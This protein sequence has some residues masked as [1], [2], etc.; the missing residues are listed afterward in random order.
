[1][2]TILKE[3]RV[4]A[5]GYPTSGGSVAK[6]SKKFNAQVWSDGR[7]LLLDSG[8][9]ESTI[10]LTCD[11][12]AVLDP[13]KKRFN[14][15]LEAEVS[16]AMEPDEDAVGWAEAIAKALPLRYFGGD[17][18]NW[19]Q[20]ASEVPEF[21]TLA[22]EA[23][24]NHTEV[25]GLFRISGSKPEID[26][27]RRLYDSG[28]RPSSLASYDVHTLT[29]ALKLYLRLLPNPL[30]PYASYN[31]FL[32]LSNSP[33]IASAVTPLI[34]EF[35]LQNQVV[36]KAICLFVQK[37][38]Q[39]SSVNQMTYSNLAIVVAPNLIRPQV[40]SIETA[41]HAQH[42]IPLF[43]SIFEH[44]DTIFASVR[45]GNSQAPSTP[46]ASR[47]KVR[48]ISMGFPA[49]P[50]L[51]PVPSGLGSMAGLPPSL[52]P[53]PGSLNSSVGGLEDMPAGASRRPISMAVPA[54][55]SPLKLP[56]IPP[57]GAKK[58]LRPTPGDGS[59]PSLPPPAGAPPSNPAPGG[60]PGGPKKMAFL[61]QIQERQNQKNAS[62]ASA[63]PLPS[64]PPTSAPGAP[65][66]ASGF[67]G[68]ISP[69]SS[70]DNVSSGLLKSVSLSSL[71][72]T[73]PGPFLKRP[74]PAVGQ[75]ASAAGQTSGG[76][77]E[78]LPP[79]SLP[80][81]LPDLPKPVEAAP[82]SLTPDGGVKKDVS[83]AEE[84]AIAAECAQ[85][86]TYTHDDG[87]KYYHNDVTNVTTWEKPECLKRRVKKHRK[88]PSSTSST[89][90][91]LTSSTPSRSNA[92]KRKTDRAQTTT[93]APNLAAVNAL[94]AT[95][96]SQTSSS[97]PPSLPQSLPPSLPPAST[98]A[99]PSVATSK[100]LTS[101][102]DRIKTLEDK[103]A[104]LERLVADQ[105][106][107]IEQLLG[108]HN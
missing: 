74:T 28:Q 29:G 23:L 103:V 80:S 98:Q 26:A 37:V 107:A 50:V 25:D 4:E 33:D 91:E 83:S 16:I 92:A 99:T 77:S 40:E 68:A 47:G 54:G 59:A 34:L 24:S 106:K 108:T 39:Q 78:S 72:K 69:S 36:L 38:G 15:N 31:T 101:D 102:S 21:V 10:L 86:K 58:G 62:E 12:E 89:K 66:S 85:W 2:A 42:I 67:G 43:T 8:R 96:N 104:A 19:T 14:L 79:P 11:S 63:A 18:S 41:T 75:G 90:E 95:L 1:M 70:S 71:P 82:T 52:P 88:N 53:V 87:R 9:V 3:G 73:P 20:D 49:S 22:L 93:S 7:I 84:E 105:A 5:K 6:S 17:M 61:S 35:P 30:V 45:G 13:K 100:P 94:A 60:A 56:A 46:G 81:V 57:G 27:L 51:P 65:G 97:L 32:T 55:S 64:L 76:S 48:P 44:A